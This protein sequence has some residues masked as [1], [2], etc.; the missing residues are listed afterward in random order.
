MTGLPKCLARAISAFC[1][2]GKRASP[3]STP[4]SPRATMITSDARITLSIASSLATTSAR[5][6]LATMC[7]WQPA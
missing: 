1:T 3:I 4:K 6:T 7:A 2:L 5:S